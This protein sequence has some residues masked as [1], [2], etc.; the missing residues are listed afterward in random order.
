MKRKRKRTG[1]IR[2]I[3]SGRY[4]PGDDPNDESTEVLSDIRPVAGYPRHPICGWALTLLLLL[5]LSL[6]P[7]PLEAGVADALNAEH[8]YVSGR[9]TNTHGEGIERAAVSV[10]VTEN[11]M[12]FEESAHDR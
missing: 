3:L 4:A 5:L 9:I 7:S 8:L 2:C 11:G 6:R 1:V 10:A 12:P